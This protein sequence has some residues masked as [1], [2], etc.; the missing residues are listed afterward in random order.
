MTLAV[1]PSGRHLDLVVGTWFESLRSVELDELNT[2]AAL[3]TR[4]DRKYLVTPGQLHALIERVGGEVRVLDMGGLRRFGYESLYFDTPGFDSYR[5]AAHRR[6]NRFKVRTRRYLDAPGCWVEVK[7]RDRRGRTIKHRQAHQDQR[8]GELTPAARS[9]VAGFAPIRHQADRL[10]PVLATRYDRVTVLADGNRVTIDLGVSCVAPAGR[11]S[12]GDDVV[13]ET[14]NAAG[15]GLV[16]R[17]LWDLHVRPTRVSKFC[18]GAAALYPGLP[19]N[20]WHRVLQRSVRPAK[21]DHHV[22]LGEAGGALAAAD[23]HGHV[24]GSYY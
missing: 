1:P 15:P 19:A 4:V 7:L 3:Q 8:F 12:L 2:T 20:R 9:F 5:G 24:A 11:V 22:D 6:P 13:V 18:V 17:A 16:D 23:A 10:E 21:R 14:K